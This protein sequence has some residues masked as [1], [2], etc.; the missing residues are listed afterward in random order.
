MKLIKS[1]ISKAFWPI[2]GDLKI[3]E[4]IGG[5]NSESCLLMPNG[6]ERC[7]QQNETNFSYFALI[8]Y[9]IIV[10][11]VNV[12]LLNLLIAMFG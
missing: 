12:L 2:Y 5:E 10:I 3:L 11:I 8:L 9:M 1:L 7:L 4:E 6:G